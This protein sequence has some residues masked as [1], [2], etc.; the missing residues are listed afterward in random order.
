MEGI[1]KLV[2]LAQTFDVPGA[3]K[4]AVVIMYANELFNIVVLSLVLLLYSLL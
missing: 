2:Q 3:D 1:K 4:K